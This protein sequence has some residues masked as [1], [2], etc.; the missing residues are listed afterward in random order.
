MHHPGL[1]VS[2]WNHFSRRSGISSFCSRVCVRGPFTRSS[3]STPLTLKSASD[4]SLLLVLH[5]LCPTSDRWHHNAPVTSFLRTRVSFMVRPSL[6]A[7]C[8]NGLRY[9]W[10]P[11]FNKTATRV[12]PDLFYLMETE[13]GAALPLKS[14]RASLRV[15]GCSLF[16]V[17]ID[18]CLK[19]Q[20]R[21]NSRVEAFPL[22]PSPDSL[23][24]LPF[25]G[26]GR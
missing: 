26:D 14:V 5:V 18:S 12:I 10:A 9:E 4:E 3:P 25:A 23:L 22:I 16:S 13:T 7:K 15:N 8:T 24:C 11:A 2:D 6:P 19:R 17:A 1:R 20:I 21:R